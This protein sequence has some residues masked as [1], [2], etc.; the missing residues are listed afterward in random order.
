MS[1]DDPEVMAKLK[2]IAK[3]SGEVTI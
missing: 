2:E 3:E 1:P